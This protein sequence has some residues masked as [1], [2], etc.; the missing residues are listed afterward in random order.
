MLVAFG[1]GSF[2][3]AADLGDPP[4]VTVRFADLNLS[5]P[6]GATV[7]YRRLESA[8]SLVCETSDP[9]DGPFHSLD[10]GKC[11]DR[12]VRGSVKKISAPLLTAVYNAHNRKPLPSR[13]MTALAR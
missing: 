13:T 9:G 8:A 2:S 5:S 12:A 3:A 10:A 1:C 7:L 6:Q 11:A 4:H